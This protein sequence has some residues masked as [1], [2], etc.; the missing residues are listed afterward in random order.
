MAVVVNDYVL[1]Y[2]EAGNPPNSLYLRVSETVAAAFTQ[3]VRDA[4]CTDVHLISNTVTTAEVSVVAGRVA[5]P[6]PAV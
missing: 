1:N 4:G 3:A 5:T 6:P 2:T